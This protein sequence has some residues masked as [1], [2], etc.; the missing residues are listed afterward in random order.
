MSDVEYN[1]TRELLLSDATKDNMLY[2]QNTEVET[3]EEDTDQDRD[4]TI[5]SDPDVPS[6]LLKVYHCG[7]GPCHPK[8]LQWFAK[9]KV[10][11]LLL[12]LFAVLEGAV[13][14]GKDIVLFPDL[15]ERKCFPLVSLGTRL[16]KMTSI[17]FHQSL[18]L[19]YLIT[20]RSYFCY[21]V[22]N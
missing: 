3:N 18:T 17:I 19:I 7:C 11:T 9:K 1:E 4:E 8:W 12:S 16:V 13:V 10:F 21:S 6:E 2:T 15:P 20:F 14:S 5:P 22:Y